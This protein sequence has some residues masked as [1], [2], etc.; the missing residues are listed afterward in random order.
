MNLIQNGDF[1][2][3]A[4][5]GDGWM[6]FPDGAVP[7]WTVE[8]N[9]AC[10]HNPKSHQSSL[11]VWNQGS[12]SGN[13]NV[14]LDGEPDVISGPV[15]DTVKISQSVATV[16][17][18]HYVLSYA[19]APTPGVADNQMKV[20]VNGMEVASHVASGVGQVLPVLKWKRATYE[21]DAADSVTSV[22][23][24]EVGPSDGAGMHLDAVSLTP[25]RQQSSSGSGNLHWLGSA[26]L[27]KEP[28]STNKL[29]QPPANENFGP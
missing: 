4:I 7:G 16:P 6:Q 19:L 1:E 29:G 25:A 14:E 10:V 3:P 20:W 24:A 9:A 18:K 12:C 8:Y 23:F 17:G 22:V 21:F 5:T 13:Q 15:Y 11:K 2:E 27:H 26:Q 28:A